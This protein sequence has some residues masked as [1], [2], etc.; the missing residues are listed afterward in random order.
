M[1]KL[2][3]K[4]SLL[5]DLLISEM[6]KIMW[7]EYDSKTIYKLYCSEPDHQGDNDNCS[8]VDYA[9]NSAKWGL[10]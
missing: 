3:C 6:T 2:N 8:R 5:L 9:V 1:E 7:G 4:L 10:L